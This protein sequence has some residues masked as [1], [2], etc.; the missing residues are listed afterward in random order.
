MSAGTI[1]IYII[2]WNGDEWLPVCLEN[3]HRASRQ[4]LHLVIIDNYNNPGIEDLP[5]DRF[6][7]RVVKTPRKMGFAD[8]HNFGIVAAPPEDGLVVLLNQDTKSGE[9]W[10]D[11]IAECFGKDQ[12]LG[13]MMPG[14]RTYDG[15]GWD[16]NFLDCASENKELVRE[17]GEVP[18]EKHSEA[19]FE[20]PVITAAAM[21]V[22]TELLKEIALFDPIFESYYEDIDYCRRI[23]AAGWKLG[24]CP[25]ARVRHFVGSITTTPEAEMRRHI[26]VLRNRAIYGARLA[27]PK[28]LS[29]FCHHFFCDVPRRLLRGIMRT[30]SS[31]PLGAILMANGKLIKL[32]PRLLSENKDE[33]LWEADLS[34]MNWPWQKTSESEV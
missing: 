12:K 34:A 18:N 15:S 17:L 3:L 16:V 30:P 21:V 23:R 14:L 9:G 29:F 25:A 7:T 27:G 19:L 13:A 31:Q 22:R 5:L 8:A 6:E 28:R 20:L 2:G 32:L 11:Q 26:W 33:L 1:T 10:I 24:V 4:R